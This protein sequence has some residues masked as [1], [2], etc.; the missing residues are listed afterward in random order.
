MVYAQLVQQ[1]HVTE[2]AQSVM[3]VSSSWLV[4]ER[5]LHS[6]VAFPDMSLSPRLIVSEKEV[7]LRFYINASVSPQ[8]N[9]Q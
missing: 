8:S 9:V 2:F 3:K 5:A 7:C 6:L 4:D 1:G